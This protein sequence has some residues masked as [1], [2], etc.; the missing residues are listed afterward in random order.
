VVR[1]VFDI[2][3]YKYVVRSAHVIMCY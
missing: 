2:M 1:Y 3:Y